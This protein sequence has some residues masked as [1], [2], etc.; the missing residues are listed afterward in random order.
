MEGEC[1]TES[2][3]Y[4]GSREQQEEKGDNK[5]GRLIKSNMIS[6]FTSQWETVR[7]QCRNIGE[8]TGDNRVDYLKQIAK[9]KTREG[10][11]R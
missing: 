6:I 2:G 11:A 1:T 3:S 4:S 7:N 10:G 8:F 9:K 5:K